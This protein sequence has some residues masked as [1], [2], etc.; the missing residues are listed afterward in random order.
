MDEQILRGLGQVQVV[1]QIHLQRLIER[2]VA[3]VGHVLE[4]E[5]PFVGQHIGRMGHGVDM[6]IDRNAPVL[7]VTLHVLNLVVGPYLICKLVKTVCVI[8][9]KRHNIIL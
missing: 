4:R 3:A 8:L 5:Q 7:N 9:T 1:V 2:G 6:V